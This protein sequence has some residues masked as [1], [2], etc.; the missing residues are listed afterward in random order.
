M[1]KP[2]MRY[3]LTFE[4][5][6]PTAVA[7]LGSSR[8]LAAG[9]QQGQIYVWDL[10]ET[11]LTNE[12]PPASKNAKKRDAPNANPARCLHGHSN[13]ISRLIYDTAR[14]Q[15][16]SAS[17]DRS[18]RIWSLDAEPRGELEVVLD[19]QTRREEAKRTRK[20]DALTHP[21]V[22]VSKY[23]SAH[24]LKEHSDW[25]HSLAMS[26]DGKRLVSGDAAAGVVVWDLETRQPTAKCKGH[27]WNWI[28]ATAFAPDG[29]SVLVSEFRYKRDDFDIPCAGFKLW[30]IDG[31]EKLDILKV[32]F[33]KL[34]P[35]DHSYGGG[36]VWRGWTKD[37]LVALAFSPDGKIIAAGQGGETDTGKVHLIDAETGK[38]MRDIASHQYGITDV[39]FSRDG[40]LLYSAGRDT[41]VRVWQVSDGKEVAVIGAPRGGQFKDWISSFS[42]SPDE[43]WLAA[44]DISGHIAV[45]QIA[46]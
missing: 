43:K 17:F 46:E 14:K 24:T 44:A 16:I 2:T 29:Q 26:H 30:N 1:F 12:L 31:T 38:L 5:S 13:A 4:G 45:W 19:E 25:I 7:F 3:Q 22:K 20:D 36:Q 41:C 6:W 11:P 23:E 37:G 8:S 34:N 10:P 21:G 42:L 33:P 40:Q 27:P 9:N 35:L 15:L 28:V 18:I 32:Q 39:A